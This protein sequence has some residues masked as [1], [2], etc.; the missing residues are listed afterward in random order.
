MANIDPDPVPTPAATPGP[1]DMILIS[2]EP[3][4]PTSWPLAGAW[5]MTPEQAEAAITSLRAAYPR[6][7]TL[8]KVASGFFEDQGHGYTDPYLCV[9][10]FQNLMRQRFAE[11]EWRG[12]WDQQ[13]PEGV[14]SWLATAA[15]DL[16]HKVVQSSASK[17]DMDL[18]AVIVQAADV[19]NYGA[20]LLERSGWLPGRELQPR[21]PIA[22]PDPAQALVDEIETPTGMPW[23]RWQW[24]YRERPYVPALRGSD[25]AAGFGSL[26]LLVF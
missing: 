12:G 24:R 3:A 2:D 18:Y 4:P 6:A 21:E 20:M 19:A 15:M 7:Q 26:A 5:D 10:S 13:P 9:T 22:V 25:R 8:Q 16:L 11:N 1:E 17:V 14:R 23:V